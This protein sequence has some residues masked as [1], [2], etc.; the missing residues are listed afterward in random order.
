MDAEA[1]EPNSAL[2]ELPNAL[3]WSISTLSTIGYGQ[4]P[5]S[6]EGRVVTVALMISGIGLF[7]T[8]AGLFASWLIRDPGAAENSTSTAK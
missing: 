8:A 2:K 5:E 3:W 6:I 7:S 4:F 1:S